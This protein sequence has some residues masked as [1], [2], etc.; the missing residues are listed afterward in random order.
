MAI[1]LPRPSAVVGLTRA[2]LD[3]AVGSAASFAAV[4]ARAFAVLDGVE[5]LL[6]RIN[7]LVDR[8]ERTLDRADRVVTDAEAAVREVGVISAA[9]TSAVENATS[10]AARASAAVGT[11]A[12]SA[13]TAAELLAAY[14]PALRRAAPMATRFVEQLSHEEVTAAIRLVDEL[15]KLREHLT[16]DVLPILATLDRV[17]PDLHDLLEVTRDL[18]LAV[19]GIPG[20]GMLRR[21]GEKLTDEAE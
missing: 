7:G 1:P 20:L 6:T 11:A 13:A 10:V 12:E 9:A 19:A 15:P 16:A 4:P 14:E 5:A 3:H 2:A 18:K 8:I 21:R 17:G